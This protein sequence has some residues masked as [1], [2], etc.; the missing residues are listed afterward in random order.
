MQPARKTLKDQN[1]QTNLKEDKSV[2]KF[3]EEAKNFNSSESVNLFENKFSEQWVE[4]ILQKDKKWSEKKEMLENFIKISDGIKIENNGYSNMLNCFLLLLKDSNINV[5]NTTVL[6]I[7]NFAKGLRKD[8]SLDSAKELVLALIDKL[9]EKRDKIANDILNALDIIHCYC[10]NS[11]EDLFD[12]LKAN[13]FSSDKPSIVKERICIFIEKAVLKTNISTLKKICKVLADILFKVTDDANADVRNSALRTLG[14]IKY[15]V[16]DIAISKVLN[17]ICTIKK[18][19]IDEAAENVIV[20]GIYNVEEKPVKILNNNKLIKKQNDNRINDNF[21]SMDV[22][23][24]V[25]SK[26]NLTKNYNINTDIEMTDLS[27]KTGPPKNIQQKSLSTTNLPNVKAKRLIVNDNAD[28]DCEEDDNNISN[29]DLEL[30]FIEKLSKETIELINSSKWEDR[31]T[32]FNNMA[33]YIQSFKEE[34]NRH[35]SYFLKFIKLKLKDYKES[36]FN[37]VKEAINTIQ[38][39]CEN[40]SSFGKKH[41]VG[42]CKRLI[43]KLSDNK[44]KPTLVSM[45]NKFMEYLTPKFISNLLIKHIMSNVKNPNVQKEFAI[46]LTESIEEFGINNCPVKEMVDYAKFLANNP[47]PQLRSSATSLLCGI[48]KYLGN[49]IKRFLNDIKEATLRVIE[50]EFEKVTVVL[51]NDKINENNPKRELKGNAAL[52]SAPSSSNLIDTLFTR[53][54]ISK[55]ITPKMIKDFSEGKWQL[56]KEVLDTL[57]KILVEANMR[58]VPTGLNEIITCFKNKL[59]DG[60]KNLVRFI[61][62]FITRLLEALGPGSK[63]FAKPLINPILNNLSD[64]QSLLRDDVC[65]C[66]EKFAEM[67]GFENILQYCPSFLLTDN[68]ELRHDLLKLILKFKA[69]L[70]KLDCKELIPGILSC[71]LDKTP[72]IRNLAEEITKEMLKI[73]NINNFYIAMKE[74]KPAIANTIK[75]IIEKYA[76]LI[77]IEP[78]TTGMNGISVESNTNNNFKQPDIKSNTVNATANLKQVNNKVTGNKMLNNKLMLNQKRDNSV[79]SSD[80]LSKEKNK[81]VIQNNKIEPTPNIQVIKPIPFLI[82]GSIKIKQKAKRLEKE[83]TLVFPNHYISQDFDIALKDQLS[84]FISTNYLNN[85]YS[86]DVTKYNTLFVIIGQTMKTDA[87]LFIEIIDL[88]LKWIFLRN[89][90][91]NN[92]LFFNN[93]IFE[94]LKNLLEFL[95]ENECNLTDLENNLILEIL[96]SKIFTINNNFKVKSKSLFIEFSHFM[97]FNL[98]FD[99]L[100]DKFSSICDIL[101]KNEIIDNLKNV[102]LNFKFNENINISDDKYRALLILIDANKDEN[103][104]NSI[105]TIINYLYESSNN[106]AYLNKMFNQFPKNLI[107]NIK[108][109]QSYN[110]QITVNDNNNNNN[111]ILHSSNTNS[112][113]NNNIQENNINLNSVT[114][115]TLKSDLNVC[116]FSKS[117]ILQLNKHSDYSKESLNNV[118]LIN[119]TDYN[120]IENMINNLYTGNCSDKI[121]ILLEFNETFTTKFNDNVIVL[122]KNV[123]LIFKAFSDL[124]NFIFGQ[125]SIDSSLIDLL[126][127]LLTAFFKL[128]LIKEVLENCNYETVFNAY[129]SILKSILFENLEN[130]GSQDEGKKIIKSLNALMLKLMENFNI[131]LTF[132]A[133][134]KILG[135]CRQDD[136]KICQLAIKCLLK[137]SNIFPSLINN[138]DIEKMLYYIF[139]FIYNFEK[140][141]P[142]LATQSLN[143]EMCLKILRTL[144]HEIIKIKN[145]DIWEYYKIAIENNNLPD[146]HLKRWIQ[147]IIRSKTGMSLPITVSPYKA[148]RL[149]VSAQKHSNNK[150]DKLENKDEE[151]NK[152]SKNSVQDV[153]LLFYINKL[154]NSDDK[155][156]Q[157][158][159]ILCELIAILKRNTI[160]IDTIKSKISEANYNELKEMQNNYVV[161]INKD[162]ESNLNTSIKDKVNFDN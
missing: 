42:V 130:I 151:I 128:S 20:D 24:V 96:I 78:V 28:V 146:K 51:S 40:C 76:S 84:N 89:V 22:D 90:E 157:K 32:A 37:I 94:F 81:K 65:K 54:D 144:V 112:N 19:K 140:T 138:L 160:D 106:K 80:S 26:S 113:N 121:K 153:E 66:L 17:Q 117:P 8:L 4:E 79:S 88:W 70:I 14:V 123:D 139:E 155:E 111:H 57:D 127:Y 135:C 145:E 125:N 53:V 85:A 104:R 147:L 11:L 72:L 16:G 49:A 120:K 98:I 86:N 55:K 59:S 6:A 1:S 33:S 131:N 100:V 142:D 82:P 44:L 13:L 149:I 115:T 87:I 83:K 64:K 122:E 56:K 25:D 47:N 52:E 91:M 62:Q 77:C 119:I 5:V 41:A 132:S 137:L 150:K 118:K 35:L 141:N 38:V 95:T 43:E 124:M 73:I 2:N 45:L 110:E 162:S 134:I 12:D 159:N 7:N 114:K 108:L 148:A 107:S 50:S 58:I 136:S 30:F 69:S 102:T 15:R 67:I 143:D 74:F 27:N 99:F 116:Q 23:V 60:N 63:S 48:Y 31:R 126:K 71:L 29:E 9:K 158:N 36:N 161:T 92:N 156:A 18:K 46:F 105:Y 34:T 152:D 3:E 97:D 103:I 68:Y 61:L 109:D 21:E 154:N 101:L 133:L 75:S 129:C 93:I 10:I 39:L